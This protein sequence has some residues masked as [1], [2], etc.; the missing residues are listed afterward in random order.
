MI[1]EPPLALLLGVTGGLLQYAVR[2]F[3]HSPE[4]LYHGLAVGLCF[5][6]YILVTP[7][8]NVGEWREVTINAVVW[9]AERVP[10]VWGGTFITSTSA[11]ALAARLGGGT[12]NLLLPVTNSK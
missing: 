8:W 4:Y 9:L 5:G 10:T 3:D 1:L 12:G 11:K 6:L 7:G 2:Q